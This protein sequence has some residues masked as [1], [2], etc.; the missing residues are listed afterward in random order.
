VGSVLLLLRCIHPHTTTVNC[1]LVE[2]I[3]QIVEYCFAALVTQRRAMSSPPNLYCTATVCAVP[4][5][6]M[7]VLPC[8]LECVFCRATLLTYSIAMVLHAW[9]LWLVIKA[10]GPYNAAR[11]ALTCVRWMLVGSPHC[12]WCAEP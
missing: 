10:P 8:C 3:R 9:V 7:P 5:C 1:C 6:P 12:C 11:T 4:L 2:I